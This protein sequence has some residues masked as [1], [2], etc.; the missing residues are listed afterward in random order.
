MA[1][2]SEID[3]L[4]SEHFEARRNGPVTLEAGGET[5]ALTIAEINAMGTSSREGGAFS[6]VFRGPRGPV[7]EQAIHRLT[8]GAD[9]RADIFLVP[10]GPDGDGMLYE[11]VFT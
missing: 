7:V 2:M 6:V 4:T 11:A 1:E 10:L 9:E 8:F 5:M 3:R